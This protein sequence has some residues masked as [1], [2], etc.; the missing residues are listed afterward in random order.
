M[1]ERLERFWFWRRRVSSGNLPSGELLRWWIRT[2]PN[3]GI[4]PERCQ[5]S[6][7]ITEVRVES[8]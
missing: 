5:R 2:N 6:E 7:M 8:L 1:F 4:D 3:Q